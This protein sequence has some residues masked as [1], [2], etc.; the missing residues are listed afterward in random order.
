MSREID[1]DNYDVE[2]FTSLDSSHLAAV[3]YYRSFEVLLVQFTDT[4]IWRYDGVE[5]GV[6]MGLRRAWSHGEYFHDHIRMS[7]PYERLE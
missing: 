6:Y 7:Y 2:E 4:S 5:W 3:R 1:P